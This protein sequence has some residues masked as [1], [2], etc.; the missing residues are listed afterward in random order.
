MAAFCAPAKERVNSKE[1]PALSKLQKTIKKS[2]SISGIGLFTGKN[3]TLNIES[4]K[5]GSGIHFQRNDLE[6]KPIIPA[7]IENVVATPRCTILGNKQH[8]IHTVEHI[9]AALT[10]LDIDNALIKV[11]GPEIPILDGSSMPFVQLIEKADIV[12]Q[13]EEKKITA[14]KTPFYWSEGEVHL[15]ALPAEEFRI[16]YTLHYPH[17]NLIRSQYL[18]LEINSSK[19]KNEI[20]PCRTFCLYEEIIPLIEKGLIKGGNL[21]NGII[22]KEDRIVNATLR[23]PDEMVRHKILDLIGD[24]SLIPLKIIAHIIAIRSG[25][26][27]NIMFAKELWNHIKRERITQENT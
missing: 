3:I 26:F 24:L 2:A 15:I 16:S 14:I 20:A 13:G 25:H 17:S 27:S 21:E 5:V 18:S 23:F 19:F 4:A 22:I 10:A 7:T 11:S 12:L 6:G 8:T 9:L 1:V